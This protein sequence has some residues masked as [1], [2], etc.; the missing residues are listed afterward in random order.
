MT[1]EISARF[2]LSFFLFLPLLSPLSFVR[3]LTLCEFIG[4]IIWF[5]EATVLV[6][7]NWFPFLNVMFLIFSQHLGLFSSSP[8]LLSHSEACFTIRM[9]ETLTSQFE[10]CDLFKRTLKITLELILKERNEWELDGRGKEANV[11]QLGIPRDEG[12]HLSIYEP[13]THLFICPSKGMTSS[14]THP[15]I[16]PA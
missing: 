2:F 11:R 8:Q 12:L 10:I 6:K 13:S 9:L 15:S 4:C 1:L 7:E 14:S 5:T 16:H 3:D